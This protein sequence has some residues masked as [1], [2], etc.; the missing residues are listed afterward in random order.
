[1]VASAGFGGQESTV[2][3]CLVD[4]LD[5]VFVDRSEVLFGPSQLFAGQIEFL[6]LLLEKLLC[7]GS[8][9][10]VTLAGTLQA[11]NLLPGTVDSAS[12]SA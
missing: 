6:G 10:P 9:L 1:M 7:P 3:R 2:R 5:G 8:G 4:A 12:R 11:S